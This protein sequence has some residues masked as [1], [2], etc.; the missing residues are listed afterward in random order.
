LKLLNIKNILFPTDFSKCAAQALEH[1]LFLAR[2]FQ[3]RLHIIHA[4]VLH[5]EDPHNP[6]HHFPN[7]KELR[8]KLENL[9]RKR[10]DSDLASCNES[11]KEVDITMKELRGLSATDLILGYANEHNTDL[12]VMGTHGRRG[13]GYMFLGSI[14]QEV[15]REASCPVYTIRE[16]ER[17]KTPSKIDEIL[18]P[19]DFSDHSKLAVSTAKEVAKLYNAKLQLLHVIEETVHPIFYT[20]AKASILEFRP[21]IVVLS[22]KAMRRIFGDSPGPDIEAEFKVVTGHVVNEILEYARCNSIDLIVIAT[23]GLSGLKHLIL[24]SVAEK[25]IRMAPCPVLTVRAFGKSLA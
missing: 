20:S 23:H 12:I 25:V 21:D 11:E 4:I 6:A 7:P 16:S 14:A 3:A 22:K 9:A 13:L 8:E 17:P 1:A 19:V 24:G 18:S 15:V 10:M 5:E 2:Y